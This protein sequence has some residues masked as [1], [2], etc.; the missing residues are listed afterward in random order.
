MAIQMY[1]G[2]IAALLL[3]VHI[4]KLPDKR[5]MEMLHL[6][7]AGMASAAELEVFLEGKLGQKRN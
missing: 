6:H 1:C 4:G 7:A 2:L 5:T 3:S